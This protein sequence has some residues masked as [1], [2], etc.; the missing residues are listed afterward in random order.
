MQNSER[1]L[2]QVNIYVSL[3]IDKENINE[4]MMLFLEKYGMSDATK[5]NNSFELTLSF[6]EMYFGHYHIR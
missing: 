1:N 6:P 4:D 2:T 5:E 3:F